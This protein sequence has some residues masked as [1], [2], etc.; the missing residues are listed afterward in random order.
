MPL[1]LPQ[2]GG[3]NPVLINPTNVYA[4]MING[5]AFLYSDVDL[6]TYINGK[7]IILTD[8]AGKQ[9]IGYSDVVGSGL[10]YGSEL[11]ANQTFDDDSWWTHDANWVVGS[12]VITHSS[13]SSGSVYKTNAGA[14]G[15]LY[16]YTMDITV[17]AQSVRIGIGVGGYSSFYTT[18]GSKTAVKT[19]LTDTTIRVNPNAAFVGTVDNVSAKQVTEPPATGLHI[20]STKG[21]STQNWTSVESGF[22]PNNITSITIEG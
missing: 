13:G 2:A 22:D 8:S 3:I 16:L 9:A 19:C 6:S 5:T 7:Y 11:V 18:S 4:S 20:V 12:G 14:L 1:R 21:G 17:S 15:A 10:T